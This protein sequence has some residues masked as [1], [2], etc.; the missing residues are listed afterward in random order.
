MMLNKLSIPLFMAKAHTFYL[1]IHGPNADPAKPID[2]HASRQQSY[3]LTW[4]TCSRTNAKL[5]KK[6]C[7][8]FA[9]PI[10][11]LGLPY[12]HPCSSP[13]QSEAHAARTSLWIALQILVRG[14]FEE[15]IC[16][17]GSPSSIWRDP[18]VN[19]S[20]AS[21]AD[22]IA[23]RYHGQQH[24]GLLHVE[25]RAQAGVRAHA[26]G[27]QGLRIKQKSHEALWHVIYLKSWATTELRS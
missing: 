16:S 1:H 27:P 17:G 2:S 8:C 3:C 10:A 12:S 6:A 13:C 26:K 18:P 5:A 15:D 20:P 24:L 23:P 11:W 4:R 21:I 7:P 22:V 14:E 25:G 9:A 19:W